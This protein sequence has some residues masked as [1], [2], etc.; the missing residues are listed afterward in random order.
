MK[1]SR[2]V[3]TLLATFIY[4]PIGAPAAKAQP[5]TVCVEVAPAVSQQSRRRRAT[6]TECNPLRARQLAFEQAGTNA[7]NALNPVC[8][9]T[10]TA[11]IAQATCAARGLS[12]PTTAT[13]APSRPPLAAIGSPAVNGA[14]RILPFT[15]NVK[16]C[17]V[18][19]NLPN[20][21]QT[22]TQQE[23]LCVFDNFRRTI[24]TARARARCAVECL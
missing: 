18:I 23:P 6:R 24:V 7:A 16:R 19:R 3:V 10:I 13:T 15:N 4:A 1:F 17:A 8:R 11:A 5:I 21:T 14:R 22:A 12:V 2:I 9:A 20:E